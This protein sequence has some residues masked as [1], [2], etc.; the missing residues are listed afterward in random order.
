MGKG[1]VM[2][3][4]GVIRVKCACGEKLSAPAGSEGKKGRCP[5]CGNKILLTATPAPQ[6]QTVAAAAPFPKAPPSPFDAQ[7]H[8][9]PIPLPDELAPAEGD[10]FDAMYELAKPT[11]PPAIP[12]ARR[13][14][15][16]AGP[17]PGSAVLC[18]QCGFDTRTG[19][20]LTTAPVKV[21]KASK[22]WF[23]GRAAKDKPVDRMAAEGSFLAGLFLS[24]VFAL[25]ASVVWFLVAWVSGFSIG[26][27]AMLIGGA[28]GVGMQ[29]GNK[30]YS[31]PGGFAAMAMTLGAILLAKI[32]VFEAVVMPKVNQINPNMSMF[33]LPSSILTPYFVSPMG[34]IIIAVG[35]IFAY[36]T[37]SGSV[38]K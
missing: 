33:D 12:A 21:V 34:L 18:T 24:A 25:A 13:C 32:A 14:P 6:P 38:S 15:Q 4:V 7:A 37:A 19:K 8:D 10:P 26:Y 31:T 30:G 1:H 20:K 35:L 5:A 29:I 27:I 9:E 2:P 3:E 16:C 23:G 11:A 36:R 28:A 17:M 22:P